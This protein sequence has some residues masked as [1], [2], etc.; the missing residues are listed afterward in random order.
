MN[1][2]AWYT[3]LVDI[4]RNE[5]SVENNLTRQIRTQKYEGVPCRVYMASAGAPQMNQAAADIQ[6]TYKL[7]CDNAVDVKAGDELIIHRGG[8]L[9]KESF[10]IR[11]FAGD[12]HYYFEPFGSV[13][14]QLEH[15]EIDLK[16]MERI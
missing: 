12:P 2:S 10:T 6:Q 1:F 9:G 11:A 8:L 15:Q 14:P 4:Y 7:A 16:Q 5:Q 13:A 3:D